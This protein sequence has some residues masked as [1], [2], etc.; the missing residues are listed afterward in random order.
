MS[1][2]IIENRSGAITEPCGTPISKR[3]LLER[4][5]FHLTVNVLLDRKALTKLYI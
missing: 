3:W 4:V 5:P 1:Y 2:S